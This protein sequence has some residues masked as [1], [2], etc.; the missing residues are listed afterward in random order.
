MFK[1]LDHPADEKFHAEGETREEAFKAAVEAFSEITGGDTEGLYTHKV[2]C[3]S[4]N[5]EALLYDFL[6]DLVVLQDTEGVVVA[7]AKE[8][9]IEQVGD[10]W[11]LKSEVL[12]DDITAEMNL[13]DI[14]APTYNEMKVDYRDGNW[15]LEAVLDI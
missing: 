3:E 5:L 2:E 12:V 11:R 10:S 9:S 15:V 8:M 4:E 7:K 13:L 6:D 14:K 1:I